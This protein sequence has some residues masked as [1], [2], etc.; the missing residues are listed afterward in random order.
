MVFFLRKATSD[1]KAAVCNDGTSSRLQPCFAFS[2]FCWLFGEQRSPPSR[3]QWQQQN[4]FQQRRF[5]KAAPAYLP[6]PDKQANK[7]NWLGAGEGAY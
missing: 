5:D 6:G 7:L 4:Q 2:A 3:R 1:L